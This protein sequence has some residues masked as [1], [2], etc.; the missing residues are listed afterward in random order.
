MWLYLSSIRI[1]S[2]PQ[3]FLDKRLR[4]SSPLKIRIC[5]VMRIIV[6]Y[7]SIEFPINACFLEKG[8]LVSQSIRKV[9]ILFPKCCR[10]GRLTV[11]MRQHGIMRP[12]LTLGKKYL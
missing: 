10:R 8:Y 2:Q 1:E 11:R 3:S 9:G 4:D 7:S 12:T 5:E 6:P